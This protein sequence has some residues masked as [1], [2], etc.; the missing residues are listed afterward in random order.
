MKKISLVRNIFLLFC[1]G[2]SVF[3]IG[4]IIYGIGSMNAIL[5][6]ISYHF[7]R[8]IS[9]QNHEFVFSN[10]IPNDTLSIP[11][12]S[13]TVPIIWAQHSDEDSMLE[14]LQRGVAHDPRTAYPDDNGNI[15]LTGHSSNFIFAP[16][17]YNTVFATLGHLRKDDPL[18]ITYHDH[19]YIFRVISL[20][21]ISP[22]D[23][24]VLE[25]TKKP[26][27]TLMTCWPVGTNIKRLIIRAE[28][29]SITPIHKTQA[30]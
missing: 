26:T 19:R 1:V 6:N 17:K 16:G 15:F 18:A 12:L 20:S 2:E 4:L 28:R 29:V 11:S 9:S 24:S 13:I 22:D 10:D 25:P 14:S 5:K 7:T 30:R 23:L 27:L 8:N 21:I 3:I